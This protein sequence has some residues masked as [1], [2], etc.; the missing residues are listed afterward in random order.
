MTKDLPKISDIVDKTSFISLLGGS[1]Q[2]AYPHVKQFKLLNG[3]PLYI[4]S[5][6][7]AHS[8]GDFH[9]YVLVV[10]KQYMHA[11]EKD[12]YLLKLSHKLKIVEGGETRALSAK[13]GCMA[14]SGKYIMIH[15]AARP[16]VSKQIIIN[17][18][19]AL[20]TH[21]CINT[22]IPSTDTINLSSDGK[23][24]DTILNR[25]R[26]Y[27]GQTPQS[28]SKQILLEIYNSS[29]FNKD[30]TDEC[31]QCIGRNKIFIVKGEESNWKITSKED[32]ERITS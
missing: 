18:L 22:C 3:I 29:S 10:H 17:H 24:V 6:I 1:S 12:T 4:H 31:S 21:N 27:Q 2:R 26:C 28:F 20:N 32:C 9:E 30:A 15:D 19:D 7:T 13:N 5:L 16:F 14:S 23:Y 11:I 8:C 25:A